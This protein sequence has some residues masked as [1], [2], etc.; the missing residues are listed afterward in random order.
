M[1]ADRGGA[2]RLGRRDVAR[3]SPDRGAV[4]G[5]ARGLTTAARPEASSRANA[6]FVKDIRTMTRFL[7]AA[8]SLAMPFSLPA[9]ARTIELP[10][11]SQPEATP[12]VSAP[13][14]P[15]HEPVAAA[16]ATAA[17]LLK[18]GE[19]HWQADDPGTG[20]VLVAVSI[21]DQKLYAY[22]NGALF[23]VSTVSTGKRGHPT[24]RGTF[25]IIEKH[26]EHFSNLYNNAP[27]PFMQRLTWDGIALHAGKL[28][29]YPASHGCIRLPLAFAKRLFEVTQRGGTVVVTDGTLAGP[30]AHQAPFDS[31]TGRPLPPSP[32]AVGVAAAVPEAVTLPAAI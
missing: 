23:A 1:R 6:R 9:H 3:L 2:P 19:F 17:G 4:A 7:A 20:Q 18:P 24:P 16:V 30:E 32:P 14:D 27:M 22:R 11:A 13:T 5:A 25:P 29:G 12:P 8:L 26:R 28:P 31:R 21:A 15:V 10:S